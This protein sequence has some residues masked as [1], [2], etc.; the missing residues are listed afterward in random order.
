MTANTQIQ[1]NGIKCN[2]IIGCYPHEKIATQEIVIDLNVHLYQYNWQKLDELNTTIN[3]D[4]L[5]DDVKQIVNKTK[6]NLLESLSQYLTSKLFECYPLIAKIDLILTK[7]VICGVK[8]DFIKLNYTVEREF[9]IALSLGSNTGNSPL[10]QLVTAIELITEFVDDIQV[11]SFYE[12]K[13]YGFTEQHNFYNTAIT[14]KC[15]LLPHQLLAKTKTIEKLMNKQ[16][17]FV[18]GPRAIDIDLLLFGDLVY[19]N[20]FLHIP[21]KDLARRDFVLVPL[22]DIAK[23]WIH[24][25]LGC[26]MENLLLQ[27]NDSDKTV[28]RS[29]VYNK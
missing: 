25:Q 9:K 16:E 8:A 7:P 19:S 10:Q 27:L 2:A 3:Y 22:V 15:S 29:V 18:N 20:Q 11:G 14:G 24:P 17:V 26:T 5:I 13:P 21:H 12:T 1:I 4:E 28:L 6:F 23:E